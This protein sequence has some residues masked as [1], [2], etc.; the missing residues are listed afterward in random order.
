MSHSLSRRDAV[1]SMTGAALWASM[2]APARMIPAGRAFERKIRMKVPPPGPNSLAMLERTKKSLGRTNYAGLYSICLAD[3]D[4]V[5]IQDLDGNVYL[6]CLSAASSNVL[7]YGRDEVARAYYDTASRIQH[8]C[9]VYSANEP[10]VQLAETLNRLMPSD[11]PKK[12]ILGL[13]GSDSNDGAIEAARRFT[14]RPGI[15]SFR[16]AYH[17]STGLSQAASGY[18]AVNAGIYSPE[19]PN[20]V[21]TDFPR[22]A[23]ER[24]RVL[25]DV[26]AILAFGKVGA[27]MVE[28]VQGDGGNIMPAEGFFS[29]L[30]EILDTYGVLLVCD[31]VQ[32]GMGRTGRWWSY[33]HEGIVPDLMA[34]GKGLSAGYAPISAL[35][36]RADVLDAL[37]SVQHVFTYSG[38]P[39]SAA[40]AGKVIEIIERDGIIANA[41]AVGDAL[42]AGLKDLAVKYPD[43]IVEA[44]GR[45]LQIG[46]EIDLSKSP[47]AGKTFAYRCVEKGVY[48]GYF[49]DKQRVIRM[50]P[51][52]TL[53][54]AEARIILATCGEVADEMHRGLIPAETGQKVAK[55]AQGW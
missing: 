29:R 3:G 33:M 38:H 14:G 12:T 20:F 15:L 42:L 21:K 48:P 11:S 16:R 26:E 6:D 8:T 7:G 52:L 50:H 32:S 47:L 17:G 10:C 39:P 13:S 51:P 25:R 49:G 1:K 30:K 2:P 36:G 35:T 53:S 40:V 22:T 46:I 28:C 23:E 41:R 4:G 55:Y 45:G 54:E 31:E 19:D 24:D 27:V 5:Y 18:P 9:L 34:A 44:R 37:E 43:V